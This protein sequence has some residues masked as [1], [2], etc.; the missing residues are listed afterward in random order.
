MLYCA[1][2]CYGKIQ[3]HVVPCH[4]IAVI[5]IDIDIDISISISV[6]VKIKIKVKVKGKVPCRGTARVLPPGTE[7]GGV[8]TGHR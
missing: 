7:A 1:I 8:E 2:L 3:Y 4:A 5:D 6:K